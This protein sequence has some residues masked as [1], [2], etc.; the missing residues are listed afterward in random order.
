MTLTENTILGSYILRWLK[1]EKEIDQH[2]GPRIKPFCGKFLL[3]SKVMT[4]DNDGSEIILSNPERDEQTGELGV[5]KFPVTQGLCELIFMKNPYIFLVTEKDKHIYRRILIWTNVYRKGYRTDGKIANYNQT[6]YKSIIK[7]ILQLADEA[8]PKKPSTTTTA[9]DD[10]L[11]KKSL[12]PAAARTPF[13]QQQKKVQG[14]GLKTLYNI[15]PDNSDNNTFIDY[16]YWNN[17]NEL[18]DRL[19]LLDESHAVGNT[20]HQNEINN[21]HVPIVS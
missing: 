9:D 5:R 10:D 13:M 16:I 17:P 6:K 19:H 15:V 12:T 21:L 14:R 7:K 3:G 1:K 18:V 8:T 4:F 20:G 11:L 2:F